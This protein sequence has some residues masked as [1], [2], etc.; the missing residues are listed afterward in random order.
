MSGHAI[1]TGGVRILTPF[2]NTY[3][4]VALVGGAVYSAWRYLRKRILRHRAIGSILI[5]VGAMAPAL[6]GLLSRVGL[7][8]YLYL[9]ELVGAV[10]MFVG[11]IR[12]TAPLEKAS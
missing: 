11:F 9:G 7:G 8:G 3:G 2:F 1:I 4:T 6:G 5:A 12:A 10:L